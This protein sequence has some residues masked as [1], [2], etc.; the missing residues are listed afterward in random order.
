MDSGDIMSISRLSGLEFRPNESKRFDHRHRKASRV[1][2]PPSKA[3]ASLQPATTATW[4][5]EKE[6]GAAT[7][8]P[9]APTAAQGSVS[10]DALIQQ[11]H[12]T[13]SRTRA[14]FFDLSDYLTE[15][16][17]RNK[18]SLK[19]LLAEDR[20]YKLSEHRMSAKLIRAHQAKE[21]YE[22]A[23]HGRPG[24][25]EQDAQQIALEEMALAKEVNN[26]MLRKAEERNT[27]TAVARSRRSSTSGRGR[28]SSLLEAQWKPDHESSDSSS[29]S[30]SSST[31]HP[32]APQGAARFKSDSLEH[33]INRT[34]EKQ[35]KEDYDELHGVPPSGAKNNKINSPALVALP[36]P[37]SEAAMNMSK[38]RLSRLESKFKVPPKA[39]A[40]ISL[41]KDTQKE[42]T[43]WIFRCGIKSAKSLRNADGLFD[44]SDPFVLVKVNGRELCRTPTID[45]DLNPVWN[46]HDD[47]VLDSKI[48]GTKK[49]V[50]TEIAFEIWDEDEGRN[51]FLGKV[52]FVG[53]ELAALFSQNGTATKYVLTDD[54]TL[55]ATEGNKK[56]KGKK[57]KDDPAQ[58]S[59]MLN[60][61]IFGTEEEKRT[62]SPLP[63]K[64][65][66]ARA[67]STSM[68]PT[69]MTQAQQ[70]DRKTFSYAADRGGSARGQNK[71]NTIAE[72]GR[73]QHMRRT[74][75]EMASSR[76]NIARKINS[77]MTMKGGGKVTTTF[78]M[79]IP[80]FAE[81]PLDELRRMSNTLE[82]EVFQ[83]GEI[84]I[85]EGDRNADKFYII[86]SGHVQIKKT[87]GGIN[88]LVGAMAEGQTFGE[89]ALLVDEPRAATC[90]AQGTVKCLMLLRHDF[91]EIL[92]GES[93]LIDP[94]YKPG[95]GNDPDAEGLT[96]HVDNFCQYLHWYAE[97]EANRDKNQVMEAGLCL[98]LHKLFSPELRSRDIIENTINTMYELFDVDRVGLFLLD[99]T[100]SKMI[101]VVSSNARG[102]AM[103]ISGLAGGVAR[104][105]K[106]EN[107]RD[108]YSDPRFDQKMDKSSG[109]KTRT[110]ICCP[111]KHPETG[112]VI[113]VLQ[114]INKRTGEEAEA[115]A[116]GTE[117]SK[118]AV[119]RSTQAAVAH[120]SS[121]QKA[122]AAAAT[123]KAKKK[124]TSH[125]RKSQLLET[126]KMINKEE[127]EKQKNTSTRNGKTVG[128]KGRGGRVMRGSSVSVARENSRRSL[129]DESLEWPTF[130]SDDVELLQKISVQLSR[131]LTKALDNNNHTFTSLRQIQKPLSCEVVMADALRKFMRTGPKDKETGE[132][133]GDPILMD[134]PK[135]KKMIVT[136]SVFHGEN[137]L[138]PTCATQAAVLE[139]DGLVEW[140]SNGEGTLMHTIRLSCLPRATRLIFTVHKPGKGPNGTGK[141]VGW[142][143]MPAMDFRDTLVTGKLSLNL[144]PGKCQSPTVPILQPAS[145]I[146]GECN[147]SAGTL[148]IRFPTYPKEVRYYC[149]DDETLGEAMAEPQPDS[150]RKKK[151]GSIH[152]VDLSGVRNSDMSGNKELETIIQFS[153]LRKLDDREK[154]L[155]WEHRQLLTNYPRALPKL[156]QSVQWDKPDDVAEVHMLLY[157]WRRMEPVDAL[158]LL[159]SRFPD[160][161]IRAYAVQLLDELTDAGIRPY[162]LQLVQCLKHESYH[163]SALAR[164]LVCRA[165][166]NPDMIGHILYW[167]LKSEVH[168]NNVRD[169]FSLILGEYLRAVDPA[170]RTELGHQGFVMRRLVKIAENISHAKGKHAKAMLHEELRKLALPHTFQLPL[171][172]DVICDGIDIEECRVMDSKKKPLWLVFNA[173]DY[174]DVQNSKGGD[175]V[176]DT[177]K[178]AHFKFPVLFKAGDDLR[179]D[180]LTLQLLSIMDSI[181]KTN[182]LDLQLAPYACV[183]TGDQ[184][185]FLEVV[186]HS[187]TLASV[188]KDGTALDRG[189][190]GLMAR[191]AA[192]KKA[193]NNKDYLKVW[194]SKQAEKSYR[195]GK[196][197]NPMLLSQRTTE[198]KEKAAQEAR[199][200]FGTV[201]AI[202]QKIKR[203]FMMSCAG[204]CVATFVLGIGDRHNDNLMI[205][206]GG[207][208]FHI[209]FGHFLG[210]FKSKYGVKRERA[211]FVFTNAM[212]EALGGTESSLFREFQETCGQALNIMRTQGD[213]LI[214]LFRLMISC[215]IPELE[216]ED[217]IL[218]LE[219]KLM[220]GLNDVSATEK[221]KQEITMSMNT[222][223]TRYNDA[224][225]FFPSR[226]FCFDRN[227]P[228]DTVATVDPNADQALLCTS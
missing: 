34:Y 14:N 204:Y 102:I 116:T 175:E 219:N 172:P 173:I 169:R 158:Q 128:S 125:R 6:A 135:G 75:S 194:L 107:I 95:R 184:I 155:V 198:N 63:S 209:D 170:V 7:T 167:L 122:R 8:F 26:L 69:H 179:Q 115:A 104:S 192:A 33:L 171:S 188:V 66:D 22:H 208:F 59:L 214:S 149:V 32:G 124:K 31:G 89:R 106:L 212:A 221:F 96:R 224:V 196:I 94:G 101:L 136:L 84:I 215:G 156:L 28:R 40:E 177:G 210:N 23:A 193:V 90:Q 79:S 105:G 57:K 42:F 117:A 133:I 25:K 144:W 5:S 43:R 142:A 88:K 223:T 153:L 145:D 199:L 58:G 70:A 78:L 53:G 56:K 36:D 203:S 157:M 13:L 112:D 103:P 183:A 182:G 126:L 51:E 121:E 3:L 176:S 178:L 190:S 54:P 91:Q 141:S 165:I 2:G 148:T 64:A 228:L 11:K 114:L 207:R 50:D 29:S 118:W 119:V 41:L 220:L 195:S 27:A 206:K 62:P 130:Q 72:P 61:S 129:D 160:P 205:S 81:L 211:P 226:I 10:I 71:R 187:T 140:G 161:K 110:M 139:R 185:G 181:W 9:A 30:S 111:L 52:T 123:L 55:S 186:Q 82:T 132:R 218:Y 143:G 83:D 38:G 191:F 12:D 65:F 163:D 166:A 100:N 77:Q 18:E 35:E 19:H 98:A 217:D 99:H 147:L 202:E 74:S 45:D 137:Q 67:K 197:L 227:V 146:H 1:M 113:A 164:F 46:W 174:C 87:V 73:L 162:L 47:M 180:Q 127:R 222:K 120:F 168:I 138:G 189:K 216:H 60:L 225:S 97:A 44:K 108:V 80:M 4:S 213:L 17:S 134:I 37:T 131:V 39:T 109:Y 76:R 159:D 48:M 16:K 151:R 49:W 86:E 154:R 93:V 68:K 152:Q 200:Q 20:K 150:T 24:G 15:R 201:D 21:A 85:K 92:G